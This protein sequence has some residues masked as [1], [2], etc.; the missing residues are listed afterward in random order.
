MELAARIELAISALPMRCITTM[1]RQ[2]EAICPPDMPVLAVDGGC[3]PQ[4][5]V[6]IDDFRFWHHIDLA[7]LWTKDPDKVDFTSIR[8]LPNGGALRMRAK[9]DT[10]IEPP[11]SRPVFTWTRDSFVPSS[12]IK[13]YRNEIVSRGVVYE[14]L[15][16][17]VGLQPVITAESR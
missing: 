10:L 17:R 12:L 6:G 8:A 5:H 9:Q 15:S 7:C 14:R 16:T 1:L 4:M 2:L 3:H 11:R 13:S